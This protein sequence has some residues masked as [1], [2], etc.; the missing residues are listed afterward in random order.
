[1]TDYRKALSEKL[2]HYP[3]GDNTV[4]IGVESHQNYNVQFKIVEAADL[5][6]S[7]DVNFRMNELYPQELQA[8]FRDRA[9]NQMQILKIVTEFNPD[10]VLADTRL[11][12][13]GT[14]IIG[15]D[16]V[17]ESGNGRVIALKTMADKHPDKWGMYI[18]S[19]SKYL[20]DYGFSPDV[21]EGMEYPVLVRQRLDDV[22]RVSFALDANAKRTGGFS[23]ME[24]AYI[25]TSYWS[26]EMLANFKVGDSQEIFDAIQ[27]PTNSDVIKRFLEKVPQSEMSAMVDEGGNLSRQGLE[28]IKKSLLA[29]V[30]DSDGGKRILQLF[31]ESADPLVRNI[32]RSIEMALGDLAALESLIEDGRR[33]DQYSISDD[34]SDVINAYLSMKS[35][36]QTLEDWNNTISM[37]NSDRYIDI[38]LYPPD[39]PQNTMEYKQELFH[40]LV[41]NRRSMKPL[42]TFL[43]RYAQSIISQPEV[44]QMSLLGDVSRPSKESLA[45]QTMDSLVKDKTSKPFLDHTQPGQEAKGPT[46]FQT[47][48]VGDVP[49][50]GTPIPLYEGLIKSEAYNETLLPLLDQMQEIALNDME[51]GTAFSLGDLPDD[52]NYEVQRWVGSLS[53]QM[54]G[55]KLAAMRHG[56]MM[57]DRALLNYQRRYGIDDIA[58]MFF[59]YEFWFTRTMGEWAKRAIE[60]PAWISMYARIRRHQKRMEQE[61]IPSRLKGKMRIPAR[62]LPD[63]MGDALYIDPLN[64]LFPFA[65]FAVPFEMMAQQGMNVEYAAIQHIQNLVKEGQMTAK[66]AEKVIKEKNSPV[67]NEALAVAQTELSQNG[68]LNAMSLA[69]MMM[70]PAMWWTY[71]YHILKGTPEQLY[72]LPGTRTGQAM[73]E[74]GGPLGV[75]GNIMALPEETIRKKFN[76]SNYGEWGDYY[77]DRTLAN[78]AA[79]GVISTDDALLA[80]MERQG[81]AYDLAYARVQREMALKI[82]GSQTAE[83]IKAGKLGGV[84][85]T[86]PT[87]IFPA[88]L[89]PE[90]E[91]LQRGLNAEYAKAWES[92]EN[93]N[94]KAINEFFEEHPEYQARLALF[95]EP[96]ERLRQ[97]LVSE[98]L[99]KWF[100]LELM[101]KPLVIEQ[102]GEDF[103]TMFLDNETKDY[104]AIDPAMLAYWARMLGGV[105][106]DVEE[107]RGMDGGKEGLKL[108]KPEVLAQVEEYNALRDEQFPN[109]KFL[110]DIYFGLPEEPKSTRYGFLDQYPELKEYW[111]WKDSYL[112]T[113]PDVQAY[114]DEQKKK[115]ESANEIYTTSIAQSTV[116]PEE[117]MTEQ[118]VKNMLP[119][120]QMQ[121]MFEYFS[122]REVSG[123]AKTLLTYTWESLG[124]PGDSFQDWMILVMSQLLE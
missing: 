119:A 76:L 65:Q 72:P 52:L 116:S 79:E 71:P 78:M 60:K 110:Q 111:T 34:I 4:A 121:L 57:R 23:S 24:Q 123:G 63:W 53:E 98:V 25:D 118:V 46:L 100:E 15:P 108:Y 49:L 40:Y 7:H 36:G 10:E 92:Y 75:I 115:Y 2:K 19:L 28:G 6:T 9:A 22:D 101:N 39:A 105:V 81:E 30:F 96:E 62:F 29:K 47:R 91:F 85:Y 122:G 87:T 41:V 97:F 3:T 8:R 117:A 74:W 44:D 113:H 64:Q 80:M 50:A 104:T 43:K 120:L 32:E 102:L 77:I 45:I 109:Y 69:S 54:S 51:N 66:Q 48:V 20:D 93:G 35:S 61:G 12:D 82:P 21:L 33:S 17:V 26:N 112:K 94:P 13:A 31:G 67:W 1:M 55:T 106:P 90:G 84:L 11:T 59:P 114:V 107:T 99:E 37:F 27:S 5:L 18:D 88:G 124:R 58:Q 86:L 56:E 16:M 89:L 73:R 103:E 14:P 42:A 95:D 70:T 68:E 38:G 83:A